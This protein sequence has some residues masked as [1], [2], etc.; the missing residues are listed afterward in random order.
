MNTIFYIYQLNKGRIVHSHKGI[1][2][3]LLVSRVFCVYLFTA[4]AYCSAVRVMITLKGCILPV[5]I[6]TVRKNNSCKNLIYR[7]ML[8][9]KPSKIFLLV[10]RCCKPIKVPFLFI[11]V[12][13][14]CQFILTEINLDR[15][16]CVY[17]CCCNRHLQNRKK[18]WM[19]F[20]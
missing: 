8:E 15:L 14:I 10:K 5:R 7:L 9:F 16:L 20:R 6:L 3:L 2:V 19:L 12:W 18:N 1:P 17:W 4:S 11:N 13:K